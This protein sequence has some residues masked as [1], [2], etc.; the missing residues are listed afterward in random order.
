[1]DLFEFIASRRR[2]GWSLVL[3]TVVRTSGSSPAEPG[4]KMAIAS[5]GSQAGTVGGGELEARVIAEAGQ[6]MKERVSRSLTF[7][8]DAPTAA[9]KGMLCGGEQEVFLDVISSRHNILI[10]GG[11]H[12]GLALAR[13]AEA[14]SFPYSVIDDRAEFVTQERFPSARRLRT[15]DF[16]RWDDEPGADAETYAVILTRGHL[17]DQICLARLLATPARYIGMIGSAR[18]VEKIFDALEEK[19]LKVRSDPRVHAPMGLDL[20]DNS[21]EEIAVSIMAEIIKEKSGGSGRPLREVKGKHA[22]DG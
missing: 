5:D 15:V 14:S 17:F 4:A 18:K 19:G 11:G 8:M 16:S 22:K 7:R 10:C 6:A 9:A 20:G 13:L 12:V 2:E 3:A 1:M 21:P